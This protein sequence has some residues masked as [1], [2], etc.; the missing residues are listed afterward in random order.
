MNNSPNVA[1]LQ[2]ARLTL[3]P[4]LPLQGLGRGSLLAA[5]SS[6][7]L[8][9]CRGLPLLE[10]H[11]QKDSPGRRSLTWLETAFFGKWENHPLAREGQSKLDGSLTGSQ[12]KSLEAASRHSLFYS[13][14]ELQAHC[15][16]AP[17]SPPSLFP[18]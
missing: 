10:S 17:V 15:E 8:G 1:W 6:Y 16:C 12:S 3:L 14:K 18:A 13:V 4:L 9:G 2:K 7:A 5:Q 11:P